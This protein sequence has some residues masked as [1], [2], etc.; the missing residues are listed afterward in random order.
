LPPEPLLLAFDTSAAH[1][2]AA[3]L[4]GSRVMVALR[5]DME[6]GQA[7]RLMPLLSSVL[8]EAGA[9][10]TD[11]AALGVGIGP[12]NFSGIRI[13]VAAAR[14]L[15]LSLGIPAFGVSGFEALAHAAGERDCLASLPAASGLACVAAIRDGR[16]DGAP[17]LVAQDGRL[18]AASDRKHGVV[19]FRAAD[20]AALDGRCH[21]E[22]V[23]PV[24][25]E[26]VGQVSALRLAMGER[27]ARP[28]PLYVRP[29]DAAPSR[30]LPPAILP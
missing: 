1:C 16:L 11:L 6:R 23:L 13:S 18:I 29:P 25:A 2:A 12:G 24:G 15:A 28:V 8:A 30:D 4:S 21:T 19:G 14:G 27:P 17:H 9:G 20:L 5:E 10:F 3:L 26:A 22:C 7:E